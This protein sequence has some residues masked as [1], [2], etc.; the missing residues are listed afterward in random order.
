[1][2][3]IATSG[4]VLNGA[5]FQ[6]AISADSWITINGTNLSAKTDTWNNSIVNGALPAALDGVQVM[7]GDQPAYIEYV[8]STQI[9]ALAPGVPPGT[10]AVTV[11]TSIGT[12]QPEMVDIATSQP[13]FFQWGNYVVATR[14]DFSL[15]VKSGTF[16][17]TTTIPAAPGDVIILWG[18]RI[19]P[20]ES[21][22]AVWRRN[23]IDHHV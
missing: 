7:V 13:A 2:P 5:S 1:V 14:Q 10:V 18:N 9:N 22:G 8:S 11:T 21:V 17:G 20:D 12:S 4:G 15:A 19:W 6:P 23:P 16:P 3:A